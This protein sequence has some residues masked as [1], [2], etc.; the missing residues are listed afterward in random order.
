MAVLNSCLVGVN[1]AS[2]RKSS[3][4]SQ[5]PV[6]KLH[7]SCELS[8]HGGDP[9]MPVVSERDKH[10][11]SSFGSDLNLQSSNKKPLC[12]VLTEGDLDKS[13]GSPKN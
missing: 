2:K 5:V 4:R 7:G 12:I 8:C 13:K 3:S 6:M 9:P 10:S 1:A 11:F